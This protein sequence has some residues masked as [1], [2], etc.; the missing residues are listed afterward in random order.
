MRSSGI[1]LVA[2]AAFA[3]GD[4]AGQSTL[5]HVIVPP[6]AGVVVPPRGAGGPR[7]GAA[8]GGAGAVIARTAP[9][10]FAT[11]PPVVLPATGMGLAAPGIA[12]LVLPT[13]AAAVLGS[14]IAGSRGGS[15]A[16]AR[17]R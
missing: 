4:A 11:I 1:L 5:N 9:L 2:L 14:G 7:L 8:P 17:T 6:A 10:P 13:V 15:S 12:A 3:A 16:P